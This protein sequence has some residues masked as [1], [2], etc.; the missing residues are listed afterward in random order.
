[1]TFNDCW[2]C[3]WIYPRGDDLVLKSLLKGGRL[4][5]QCRGGEL[6]VTLALLKGAGLVTFNVVDICSGEELGSDSQMA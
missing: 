5:F 1:M 6:L 2:N 4:D 3:V